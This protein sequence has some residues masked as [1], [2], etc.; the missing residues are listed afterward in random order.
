M[1]LGRLRV[2]QKLLLLVL[3]LLVL[4]V[5]GAVPLVTARIDAAEK[6]SETA[7]VVE[8]AV[9]IG[10]LVQ[11]LQQERL[12]TLGYLA[13]DVGRE[14]L[15]A[16]SARVLDLAEQLA[17]D[18][19][20]GQDDKIAALLRSVGL[21]SGLGGLRIQVLRQDVTGLAAYTG[22]T[23]AI[24][25]LV[26]ALGLTSDADLSTPVG[27]QELA[28]DSI[29]RHDEA[30]SA[31]G[32]ALFVERS[33][34]VTPA[35]LALISAAMAVE[36]RE[37][38]V[39]KPLAGAETVELY[40]LVEEGP[41]RQAVS[42]LLDQ[43]QRSPGAVSGVTVAPGLLPKVEAL[44][45]LARL[46]E[47]RVAGQAASGA[48]D[49]ATRDRWLAALGVGIALLVLIGAVVLSVLITR[50]ISRP[51]RRLTASADE[52]AGVA[53]DELVRVV[54]TEDAHAAA[55]RLRPV[56]VGTADE[57]GEL[58]AAFNRVQQ[59]AA[60]LVERQ[61]VSRRNVA[62]MFGNVGRRT[63]NLVGRQLAM[64]D[65][66]E[67]NEQDP[68]LLDRLYRLDH[69]S[70]RLRRN[71]NSLVVLSGAPDQELTGEPLSVADTIRSALGEIE[72]FQ[73]VRLGDVDDALLTPHVTP[74]VTLL[75]AE[76]L[77]NGTSFSPPHTEVD[78]GATTGADGDVLVRIV[79]HGLGM[80]AEQL[81]AENARLVE[82]ERLDLAPT[83]VLGL[84][85]VGRLARRHGIRVRLRPT[86]GTGVTAEVLIPVRQV[87]RRERS[88]PVQVSESVS[89]P[90]AEP[91]QA[92]PAG[93][94]VSASS[95]AAAGRGASPGAGAQAPGRDWWEP[96]AEVAAG[97]SV[98]APPVPET[99]P[100]GIVRRVRG[101][102]LPDTGDRVG[103]P[104]PEPAAEPAAGSPD[105]A[106]R[107]IEDF[108]EGVRRALQ[109][110]A[111]ARADGD[112]PA[113]LNG[114]VRLAGSALSRPLP[115]RPLPTPPLPPPARA[116]DPA[117]PTR[118]LVEEFEDGV[119]RA[120][121]RLDAVSR[122]PGA[123][124]N[125]SR[126]D[127]GASVF[128]RPDLPPPAGDP[129]EHSRAPS[130]P[131]GRA[132]SGQVGSAQAVPEQAE[133]PSPAGSAGSGRSGA[134]GSTERQSGIGQPLGGQ[135]GA[136]GSTER[137]SGQSGGGQS[138]TAT[139]SAVAGPTEDSAEVP[140]AAVA[141]GNGSRPDGPRP[142][143]G[144]GPEA[145]PAP[146][147]P[148]QPRDAAPQLAAAAGNG[149]HP[150]VRR[151][152]GAQLPVGA[153]AAR[154]PAEPARPE[155]DGGTGAPDPAD[156]AAR[157]AAAAR[158]LVEEFEAGV[159]RALRAGER[160]TGSTN[161]DG[162]G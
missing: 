66:L 114:H 36:D 62:T 154:P 124:T 143:T 139:E 142:G 128:E 1:L 138:G 49:S 61:V 94:A 50:S 42:D 78:V 86:P 119:R 116:G 69:V 91:A 74:D 53:R 27:R 137:Q 107:A 43:L 71:A 57:L 125:G 153:R 37:E 115:T 65:S 35:V 67:R 130:A 72:G 31:A 96:A 109:E 120:L 70:T 131:P 89:G 157:D 12:A 58:A 13:L 123:P 28:L 83:D 158:E 39:F 161:E 151:V 56:R 23:E 155:G 75:L 102:Q 90:F 44:T 132:G 18:Y 108:E 25:G 17:A 52:V 152:P 159:E 160:G 8:R 34:K 145:V 6:S 73:R 85:V 54:D 68:A 144:P 2:R 55:P 110:S 113:R 101:A 38:R 80:T 162:A 121:A 135:P 136:E 29:I 59:V 26:D 99:G 22:Y 146:D 32:A 95:G 76:L 79:D 93:V 15:V 147:D 98:E 14:R 4:V 87:V 45:S 100:G 7:R 33:R 60:D 63:Q 19:G 20:D 140:A 10:E 105:E 47:T 156:A 5:I 11:E 117:D 40:E 64:I 81:A 103:R 97:P 129:G 82:R 149:L 148:P 88:A 92:W 30:T 48:A 51:L 41:S 3:P 150:L 21:R 134:E 77:E 46:V 84:F 16:R 118:A 24:N 104:R 127:S 126:P 122:R 111:A 106:R 112:E 133:E 141:D 9:R